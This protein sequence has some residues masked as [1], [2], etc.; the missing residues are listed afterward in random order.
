MHD[1]LRCLL[2]VRPLSPIAG[3]PS[4]EAIE[5]ATAYLLR[6]LELAV[7]WQEYE[8]SHGGYKVRITEIHSG[9]RIEECSS[10]TTSAQLTRAR[11]GLKLPA[12]ASYEAAVRRFRHLTLDILASQSFPH[13]TGASSMPSTCRLTDTP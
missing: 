6:E 3:T 5:E 10:E 9:G 12:N 4:P 13:W 8:G 7:K 11:G 1:A 2:S